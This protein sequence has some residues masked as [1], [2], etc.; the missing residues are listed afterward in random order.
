VPYKIKRLPERLRKIRC[1]AQYRPSTR[2]ERQFQ[3]SSTMLWKASRRE[4]QYAAFEEQRRSPRY[5]RSLAWAVAA[6]LSDRHPDAG[7]THAEHARRKAERAK[8]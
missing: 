6:N 3:H 7:L 5:Q 8:K 2:A 4:R 1:A